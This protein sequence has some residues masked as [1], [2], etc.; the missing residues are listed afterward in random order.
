MICNDTK[1]ITLKLFADSFWIIRKTILIQC[2]IYLNTLKF[3]E[4]N[5]MCHVK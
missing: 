1:S 2:L 4:P 3:V 5:E